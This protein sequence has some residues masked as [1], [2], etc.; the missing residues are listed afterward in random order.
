MHQTTFSVLLGVL[1]VFV[2]NSGSRAAGQRSFGC[3]GVWRGP[4]ADNNLV[5]CILNTERIQGQL[6]YFSL[7]IISLV[8][9]VLLFVLLPFLICAMGKWWVFRDP[10]TR[11][12]PFGEVCSAK[13]EVSRKRRRY[14]IVMTLF[15][16]IVFL[17]TTA[18]FICL[19]FGSVSL[20]KTVMN[21]DYLLSSGPVAV[22]RSHVI[23]ITNLIK[24]TPIAD[25]DLSFL[26]DIED[27]ITTGVDE[28]RQKYFWIMNLLM[29]IFIGAG[30]ASFFLIGALLVVTA[31]WRDS[32]VLSRSTT[33]V[34]YIFAVVFM[35]L[36]VAMAVV[37]V[38]LSSLCGEIVVQSAREPGVGQWYLVPLLNSFFSLGSLLENTKERVQQALL[39]ACDDLANS[40][41]CKNNPTCQL[42]LKLGSCSRII[43]KEY[44]TSS[45]LALS[46]VAAAPISDMMNSSIRLHDA[47]Y[48]LG[49]TQVS[50][51]GGLRCLSTQHEG[52]NSSGTF[53]CSTTGENEGDVSDLE[54][55]FP[56]LPSG[57]KYKMEVVENIST[58]FSYLKPLINPN[59]L[60][61]F[62]LA[63]LQTPT[64]PK[65]HMFYSLHSSDDCSKLRQGVWG[66]A[67]GFF[68]GALTFTMM[69]LVIFLTSVYHKSTREEKHTSVTAS[70]LVLP[71]DCNFSSNDEK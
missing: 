12:S 62:V 58:A 2:V 19:T 40:S 39:R 37:A 50:S 57:D 21:T 45:I 51:P 10:I 8:L 69:L 66:V 60:L 23:M 52:E 38:F 35:L 55:S 56:S 17:S 61:D 43:P 46:T 20:Q 71:R 47:K 13:V 28:A 11:A 16:A 1:L 67:A 4:S 68:V 42:A 36:S 18:A 59:F 63:V 14:Q 22:F 41:A 48:P 33:V 32:L 24:R 15:V 27:D 53:S 9:L 65:T 31:L 6:K 54:F 29:G 44:S 25:I 3:E 49:T 34:V 7:A 5:E 26:S 70:E 30:C 64:Q